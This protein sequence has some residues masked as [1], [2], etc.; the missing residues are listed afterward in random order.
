MDNLQALERFSEIKAY[1]DAIQTPKYRN[2][3]LKELREK[4]EELYNL[5]IG[6]SMKEA[7]AKLMNAMSQILA[8]LEKLEELNST[9]KGKIWS[10]LSERG[11]NKV[12]PAVQRK[13][14]EPFPLEWTDKWGNEC[15][16]SNGHWGAKNYRV[17]D[18]IGY[19]FVLK[20]GGDSLPDKWSPIFN[21]LFDVQRRELQ[22]HNIQTPNALIAKVESVSFTDRDFRE[23]TGLKLSSSETLDLLL[24]T[25]RVEFKL[26]FPL[27]LKS[28]GNK[29]NIHRMNY[30]S[31]FFE[32]S[33][34]DLKV[35]RDGIVQ[36]R[37]YRIMFKT[38]LGELFVNN[39]LARYNDPID[40]RF[41]LL[42]ASAQILYRRLML[43]HNF[44]ATSISLRKVAEAAGLRDENEANLIN[45]IE[46]NILDPLKEFGYIEGY[47]KEGGLNNTKYRI[48]RKTRE[49]TQT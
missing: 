13:R 24:E 5:E 40:Q 47:E 33:Y 25:S 45:T 16:V 37:R 21:D 44:R 20:K 11:M 26:T 31:R 19:M 28:T 49:S 14:H 38:L 27:R 4:Y 46:R 34:E 32:L 9:P 1:Y 18:A 10:N 41:Y 8:K 6:Q 12:I 43:H 42:P 22:L 30:Y 29:E 7:Y 36:H 39:L 3:D 2:V 17:M 15:S 35:R 23:F 48:W